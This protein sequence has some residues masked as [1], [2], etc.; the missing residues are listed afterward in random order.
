MMPASMDLLPEGGADGALFKHGDGC[1]QRSG[2]QHD[3]QVSSFI[4]GEI[5]RDLG[6]SSGYLVLDDGRGIALSVQH[7]GQALS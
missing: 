4:L 2:A 5:T 7:D 6:L 3:G 1:G